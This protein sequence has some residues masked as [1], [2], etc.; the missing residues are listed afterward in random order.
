[1]SGIV[2]ESRMLIKDLPELGKSPAF[3]E[4]DLA[5]VD[6]PPGDALKQLQWRD[7]CDNFI[8]PALT[9]AARPIRR[10]KKTNDHAS[11]K[12]PASAS[13]WAAV[14]TLLPCLMENS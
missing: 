1:M 6:V 14:F 9:E 13:W 7:A 2:P 3:Y 11:G 4:P 10:D 8:S 5:L 12:T